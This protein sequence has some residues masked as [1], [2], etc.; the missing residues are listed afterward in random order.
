MHLF[1]RFSDYQH[2]LSVL[3]E[4]IS[5]LE[6]DQILSEISALSSRSGKLFVAGN[7]GSA[8]T[9][10]HFATDLRIISQRRGVTINVECLAANVSSLTAIGNDDSF[11]NIFVKQISGQLTKNDIVFVISVSG[12]SPNLVNL[13]DYATKSGAKTIGL[14]GTD[15]GQLKNRLDFSCHVKSGPTEYGPVEDIHIAICHF[16]SLSV[17]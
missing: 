2:R 1:T 8:A 11:D 4:S 17:K 10:L 15:G 12:N 13:V 7:G 3:S 5:N 14:L 9:S 16:I 6:I